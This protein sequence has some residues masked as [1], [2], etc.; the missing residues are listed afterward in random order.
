[1]GHGPVTQL[2]AAVRRAAVS[3]P[4]KS[5]LR[6]RLHIWILLP[7]APFSIV[8]LLYTCNCLTS[9]CY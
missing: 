2:A 4:F 5:G 1:M 9:P 8:F 7:A 3:W 6:A